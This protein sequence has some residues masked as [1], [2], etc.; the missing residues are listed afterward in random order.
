MNSQEQR[1]WEKIRSAVL[2]RDGYRCAVFGCEVRGAK[3]L[4]A[5]HIIPRPQGGNNPENLITLCE[6][7]HDEI[8]LAEVR[9]AHLIRNWTGPEPDA[10]ILSRTILDGLEAALDDEAVLQ[11]RSAPQQHLCADSTV[12]AIS[13][14]KDGR[15]WVD[16]ANVLRYE[17]SFAPTL[18]QIAGQRPGAISPCNED[19]L[20][21]RLGLARCSEPQFARCAMC[22]HAHHPDGDCLTFAFGIAPTPRQIKQRRQSIA[23]KN[24]AKPHMVHVDTA[25]ALTERHAASS[26]RTLAHELGYAEPFAASLS[27]AARRI[28]GAMTRR[29]ENDLRQRLD[30]PVRQ[31]AYKAL[32]IPR[33]L[34]DR[35]NARR[36]AA[37]LTWAE[38]L[39]TLETG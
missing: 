12:E 28:P 33:E 29:A 16:V 17:P 20:R 11:T 25:A 5:H 1:E 6:K 24:H 3:N 36:T 37:G 7:H 26:W 30:L 31:S 34:H 10:S 32:A 8:E 2:K 39:T 35:L 9:T 23:A 38:L 13:A 15:S 21:D 14:I 27:A 22:G 19:D 18:S 4:S